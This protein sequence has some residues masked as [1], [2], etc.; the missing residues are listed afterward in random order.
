[1][2]SL[3]GEEESSIGTSQ[4]GLR[5]LIKYLKDTGIGNKLNDIGFDLF[6]FVLLI[7]SFFLS[8]LYSSGHLMFHTPVQ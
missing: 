7:I 1:M 5:V 8:F 4:E 2:T 3:T 6:I